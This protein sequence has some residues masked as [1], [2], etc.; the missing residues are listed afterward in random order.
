MNGKVILGPAAVLAVALFFLPWI[1][2]SCD[3]NPVGEF[4]GYQLATGTF[5]DES[6]S[7]P[8]AGGEP[9]GEPVLFAVPVVGLVTLILLGI[10]LLKRDFDVNASWG[11]IIASLIGILILL[12]KWVQIQREIQGTF[13][14][15][16]EPALW[17]T[18]VCLV[19]I[20]GGALFDLILSQRRPV[21]QSLFSPAQDKQPYRPTIISPRDEFFAQVEDDNYTILDEG[22]I[23]DEVY[24]GATILD[25][26]LVGGIGYGNET[27]LDEDFVGGNVYDDGATILDEQLVGDREYG[28]VTMLDDDLIREPAQDKFTILD[29]DLFEKEAEL[30]PPPVS[31]PEP[32]DQPASLPPT[33]PMD[34]TEVLHVE[35]STLGWL[36]ISSG[37]RKGEH[38]RLFAKTTIGRDRSN[39]IVIDDTALS[40]FH[41]RINV[42]N[43]NFYIYDENSTNGIFIFDPEHHRWERKEAWELENGAQFKL[44]RTVFTLVTSQLDA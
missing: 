10:T 26:Q 6:S 2:V 1:T 24:D 9:G 27:I 12:L 20:A 23:G 31:E 14:V 43:D 17:G 40:S 39:D 15:L 37:D 19:A 28:N 13:E 42:E 11:Q 7:D 16:I 5:S 4:T 34:K 44:G 21:P 18:V 8:Y 25:D 3:G 41:A 22:L 29:E 35:S 32:M 33:I 36:L 38:I 30:I